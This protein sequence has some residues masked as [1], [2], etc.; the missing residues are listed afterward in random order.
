MTVCIETL[1][2]GSQT[3]S[4]PSSPWVAGTVVLNVHMLLLLRLP[5]LQD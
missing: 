2:L 5:R 3:Q 1:L 4:A